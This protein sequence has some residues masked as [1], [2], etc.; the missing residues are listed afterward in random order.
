MVVTMPVAMV[1]P[2]ATAAPVARFDIRYDARQSDQDQDDFRKQ[3]HQILR[4]KKTGTG[5]S[6]AIEARAASHAECM[7]K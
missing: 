1:M 2:M 3:F 7:G 4:C 6:L 5:S